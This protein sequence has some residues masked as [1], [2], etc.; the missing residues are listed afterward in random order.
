MGLPEF[1]STSLLACHGLM[2][3]VDLHIFAT[4]DASVLPS[5][6]VKNLGIHNCNFE[7]VTRFPLRPTRFSAYA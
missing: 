6:Y 4:A 5:V 3:P 7:A 1:Y 2:S